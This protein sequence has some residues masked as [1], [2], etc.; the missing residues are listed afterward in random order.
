MEE[1]LQQ[2]GQIN[3]ELGNPPTHFFNL[4]IIIFMKRLIV[5][6]ALLTAI[7][8]NAQQRITPWLDIDR[9]TYNETFELITIMEQ[10]SFIEKME[11]IRLD[12]DMVTTSGGEIMLRRE[13]NSIRII[14]V[15]FTKMLDEHIANPNRRWHDIDS[16]RTELIIQ[17]AKLFEFMNEVLSGN[18]N[19]KKMCIKMDS[20]TGGAY[21]RVDY[22][23]L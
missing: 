6:L 18:R 16:I 12:A 14:H 22:Y 13:G 15:E 4:K 3:L 10:A 1:R 2:N 19:I 8:A 5:I 17:N 21:I 7:T 20:R 11:G 9:T 23:R